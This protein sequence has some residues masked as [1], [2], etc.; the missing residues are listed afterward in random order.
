MRKETEELSTPK[1]AIWLAA[2][3]HDVGKFWKR[4]GHSGPHHEASANFIDGFR[5]LFLADWFSDLK[6]AVGHHHEETVSGD[7]ERIVQVADRLASEE[8]EMEAD[9]PSAGELGEISLVV[10][11]W[12]PGCFSAIRMRGLIRWDRMRSLVLF[13]VC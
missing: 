2:L 12:A 1:M 9:L 6:D 11:V 10:M 7:V 5:S 3:L 8:K 4:A 13:P